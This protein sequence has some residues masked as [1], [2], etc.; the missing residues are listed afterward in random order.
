MGRDFGGGF[1]EEK[2]LLIKIVFCCPPGFAN[3]ILQNCD[4]ITRKQT[5]K[6]GI[7]HPLK[8]H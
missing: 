7:Y 2:E 5:N 4:M 1:H 8:E 6:N 3:E